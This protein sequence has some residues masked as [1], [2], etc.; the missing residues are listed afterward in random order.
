MSVFNI[1]S[2]STPFPHSPSRFYPLPLAS[3]REIW[4]LILWKQSFLNSDYSSYYPRNTEYISQ[5]WN[6]GYMWLSA[7]SN[8]MKTLQLDRNSIPMTKNQND[9]IIWEGRL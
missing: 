1:L 5:S 3:N 2:I 8:E 9:I 6:H 4:F 7:Q